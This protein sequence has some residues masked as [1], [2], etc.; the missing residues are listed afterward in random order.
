MT[1]PSA[2]LPANRL[3][4]LDG[5]QLRAALL[6]VLDEV[7]RFCRVEGI[8]YFLYAGTLLGAVRNKGFIPWDD[9]IDV[10]MSRD[11]FDRFCARFPTDGRYRLV[12]AATQRS[13]PYA[14][15]KVSLAGTLV[16]EEVDLD[17]RDRFGISVDV[18]PFDVV[19]DQRWLFRVQVAVAWLVR[20]C[21][22]LK[23][24]QATTNRTRKVRAMLAVS[25]RLL[26]PV[27]VHRLVAARTA[28]ASVF[29]NRRTQHVSMLIASVPWRVPT[30]WIHPMSEI[31]F[32]GRVMPAPGDTDRFLRA[33]YGD[34]M[35]PPSE[36]DRV[37]PHLAVAYRVS[38]E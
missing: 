5:D 8:A 15:A 24:V 13:F 25:R 11:D 21:L 7:D 36:A 23:V 38:D 26:L 31:E 37:P 28:I 9:D 4:E 18:L 3:I 19:P 33:V 27:P 29:R 20:A 32:E 10:M 6:E 12:S 17:E 30:S 14:S 2:D 34:Y 16:V 1:Q 35:T 22:L